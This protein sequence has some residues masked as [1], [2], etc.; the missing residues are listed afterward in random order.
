MNEKMLKDIGELENIIKSLDGK[1]C[2]ELYKIKGE[3][4]FGDFTLS[5][6]YIP[7]NPQKF[8]AGMRAR[9]SLRDSDF[10]EKFF[11]T[12]SRDFAIRDFLVRTFNSNCSKSGSKFSPEKTGRISVSKNFDTII[13]SNAIVAS[14]SIIEVRFNVLLPQ[15]GNK[16]SSQTLSDMLV[17]RIPKVV[18][19]SLFYKNINADSMVSFLETNEDVD[20]IRK[21][22]EETNLVAFIG[23]KSDLGIHGNSLDTNKSVV[24]FESDD[25][26][27]VNFDLPNKGVTSGIGIPKGITLVAGNNSK[28]K[29][30]LINAIEQGMNNLIPGNGKEFIVSL[31][32]TVGVRSEEGRVVN[33]VDITPFFV[34][35]KRYKNFF[36]Q[37]AS[38][39][40]S[41]A[42]CLMESLEMGAKLLLMDEETSSPVLIGKDPR[43]LELLDNTDEKVFSFIDYLPVIKN[44]LGVSVIIST[45]CSIEYVRYADT[46]ILVD[47]N[48]IK[49]ITKNARMVAE[50]YPI[51]DVRP[52]FADELSLFSPKKRI[53]LSQSMEFTEKKNLDETRVARGFI[54]YGENLIDMRK[55]CPWLSFSQAK[56]ISRAIV[57]AR[58][59]ST[60]SSCLK[61]IVEKVM[62]RVNTIGLDVLTNRRMGDLAGFTKYEIAAAINRLPHLLIK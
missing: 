30:S 31:E 19:S 29:S 34:D 35:K 1:R 14:D 45:S 6:D 52:D 17:V 62:T 7:E 9:V 3:Y 39:T 27:C 46:V 28:F 60:D 61:E 47:G 11:N 41:Q 16:I 5:I 50:K 15:M 8:P 57:L 38:S 44:Q 53:P 4:S 40:E 21:K 55:A 23:E 43:A 22:L 12:Q 49:S 18:H 20:F 33:G 13:D 59:L 25:E 2:E 26:L 48:R 54:E 32:D 24:S 36:T 51:P 58:K 42:A 56:S 37:F 10:P